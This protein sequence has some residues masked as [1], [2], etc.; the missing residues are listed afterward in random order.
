[1]PHI[2]LDFKWKFLGKKWMPLSNILTTLIDY[3]H[4][5]E[6]DMNKVEDKN[7]LLIYWRLQKLSLNQEEKEEKTD[8]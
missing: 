5:I 3:S 8:C 7:T 4:G 1:M 6:N 2:N